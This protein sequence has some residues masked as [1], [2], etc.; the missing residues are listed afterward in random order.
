MSLPR[1]WLPAAAVGLYAALA[2]TAEHFGGDSLPSFCIF[3]LTT[4]VPCPGC[5]TTRAGLA[6]VTGHLAD[7]VRH[8]PLAACL[9]VVAA[10]AAVAWLIARALSREW[11]PS[12]RGRAR[13]LA[14]V[15]LGLAIGLNWAYLITR[16]PSRIGTQPPV[17]A[18]LQRN[19]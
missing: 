2:G 13:T 14:F 15:I 19:H 18:H 8:N 5:G 11:R 3:R 16:S 17:W 12:L 1:N 7:A 10:L 6:L 4:G 9:L